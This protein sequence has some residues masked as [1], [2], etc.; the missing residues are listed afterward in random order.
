[1]KRK[2]VLWLY[3]YIIPIKYVIIKKQWS[4]LACNVIRFI[5][6]IRGMHYVAVGILK[7]K[8][9]RQCLLGFVLRKARCLVG[10]HDIIM[11][12]VKAWSQVLHAY[13]NKCIW[14]DKTVYTLLPTKKKKLFKI[15]MFHFPK[16]KPIKQCVYISP[17][18]GF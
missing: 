3:L 4:F 8:W 18:L 16:Q 9:R 11:H 5:M 17:Y 15:K 10:F 6:W 12:V 14:A 2:D 1:M 7:D 13:S